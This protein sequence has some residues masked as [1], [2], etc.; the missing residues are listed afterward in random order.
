MARRVSKGRVERQ[1]LRKAAKEARRTSR[2]KGKRVRQWL[3]VGLIAFVGL[4]VIIG[5]G[6]GSGIMQSLRPPPQTGATGPG[7]RIPV[8]RAPHVPTGQTVETY[9][10]VP[11]TSG[12]HWDTPAPWGIYQEELPDE[13]VVHNVEHGGVVFNYNTEDT[14]VIQQLEEL[15]LGLP[16]SPCFLLT[17][18]YSRI[19]E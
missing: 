7:E 15:V 3:W 6:A 4:L 8:L 1:R 18:P 11:P 14:Q 12:P 13:Q 16:N 17:Q 2:A 9:N 19:E 10:S 5:F